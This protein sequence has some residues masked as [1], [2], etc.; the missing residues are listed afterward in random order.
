MELLKKS[1]D[2]VWEAEGSESVI[3]VVVGGRWYQ[4]HEAPLGGLNVSVEN[5][6]TITPR[7]SNL[8]TIQGSRH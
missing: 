7:A 6:M 2:G 1:R 5:Q 3:R 4:L 8:I